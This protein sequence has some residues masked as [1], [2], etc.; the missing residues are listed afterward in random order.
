MRTIHRE[1][2]STAERLTACQLD[3]HDRFLQKSEVHED[4]SELKEEIRDQR[5]IIDQIWKSIGRISSA[6]P[7]EAKK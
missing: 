4:I 3:M 1:V 7:D 6:I 5:K 2:T